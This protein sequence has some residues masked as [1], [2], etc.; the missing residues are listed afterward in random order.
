MKEHQTRL[1]ASEIAT[2]WSS[3]QNNSMAI[4]VFKYFLEHVEDED[5][6]SVVTYA[7]HTSEENLQES[8]R[9]L[10]EDK[11]SIPVGFSDEDV[12]VNAPRLYS[13]TYYL[14]YIKNMAKVGLSV[15]GVALA[16]SAKTSVRDWLSKAI[17][18][19]TEMYNKTSD[20]LLSKGLFI[21]PPYVITDNEIDFIDQKNYKRGLLTMNPRTINVIEITHVYANIETNLV[22]QILLSGL[23]QVAKAKEVRKYC[24][25]G[26]E[27]ATKHIEQFSNILT[28][29]YIP[30]PMPSDL[31]VSNS[32]TAPFSDKLIMFHTALLI[33]SSTS[34]YSTA[35]AASL[36]TDIV[37]TYVRLTAEV[38]T[39][40]NDGINIMIGQSWLEEPPQPINKKNLSN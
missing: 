35:A 17:Q 1:T 9:I 4:C 3:C 20:A 12:N 21:R 23:A 22:G 11:Q 18:T 28:D 14:N 5:I 2:L 31:T 38:T 37:T 27:I 25:R 34:N 36:R 39:Y 13:D 33:Q 10:K 24:N 40:A 7:L 29:D 19:S 15:Y 8:Q 32:T 30:V 16:T 26:K 6:K